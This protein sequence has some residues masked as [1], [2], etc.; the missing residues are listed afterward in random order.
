[1]TNKQACITTTRLNCSHACNKAR[2][3]VFGQPVYHSVPVHDYL[4]RVSKIHEG[5]NRHVAVGVTN[6]GI[7]PESSM[8]YSHVGVQLDGSIYCNFVKQC[9]CKML[10]RI[11]HKANY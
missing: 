4:T 8:D 7:P 9:L 3:I 5:R 11:L 6:N 2:Y 10:L 1:M